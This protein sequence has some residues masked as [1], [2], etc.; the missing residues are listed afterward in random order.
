MQA[1]GSAADP[2]SRAGPR[3]CRAGSAGSPRARRGSG[4]T[5]S[6]REEK[7]GRT[8]GKGGG[9]ARRLPGRE[10]KSGRKEQRGG[11]AEGAGGAGTSVSPPPPRPDARSRAEPLLPAGAGASPP[12]KALG[13]PRAAPSVRT[14]WTA[15]P[16]AV[17]RALQGARGRVPPSPPDHRF[18][19][20]RWAHRPG[21]AR[22]A[23]RLAGREQEPWRRHVLAEPR[24]AA[25]NSAAR[26]WLSRRKM[27]SGLCTTFPEEQAALLR[28]AVP[29]ALERLFLQGQDLG[30]SSSEGRYLQLWPKP[31]EEVS[32]SSHTEVTEPHL[33]PS[34]LFHQRREVMRAP[35][36]FRKEKV[37]Y[38]ELQ[39]PKVQGSQA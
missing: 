34:L 36:R 25:R 2:G 32:F 8:G 26:A 28:R 33:F 21:C 17:P 7:R 12:P 35:R 30:G 16:G 37:L 15:G 14:T 9:Q 22:G 29:I 11:A 13:K 10:G 31:S 24:A 20:S 27:G 1:G 5:R 3:L 4:R 38:Q 23:G 18:P 6:P 39:H 19:A